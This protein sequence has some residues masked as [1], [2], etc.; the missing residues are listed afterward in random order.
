MKIHSHM[1][2]SIMDRFATFLFLLGVFLME[3]QIVKK[4]EVLF[5][6]KTI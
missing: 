2:E 3:F 6:R 5:I 4:F 1:Y